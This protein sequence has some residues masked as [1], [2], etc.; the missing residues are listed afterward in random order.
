MSEKSEDT[1]NAE[2]QALTDVSLENASGGSGRWNQLDHMRAYN[3]TLDIEGAS[4][5]G[6]TN[7]IRMEDSASAEEMP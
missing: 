2:E 5:G 1:D 7:E 3:F 4:G 6:A